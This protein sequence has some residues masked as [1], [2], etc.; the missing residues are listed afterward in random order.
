MNLFFLIIGIAITLW[1]IIE[2]LWTTLWIDGDAGPLTSR[3]TSIIWKGFRLFFAPGS[4]RM[5]SLAG[6]VI[7]FTTVFYWIILLLLGWVL[8][9]YSDPNSIQP[10]PEKTLPGLVDYIWY[11][12]YTTFTV[13]NGDFKPNGSTW[14]ILSSLVAFSGMGMVT[15]TITYLMQVITAVNN[16]RS[17]AS[18]VT[19]VG[20]TAE[21]FVKKQ[22]TGDGFG[23]IELQLNSLN[24]Q[25]ARLSEQ[26]LAFPILH[27]YH[28]ERADKSL[29]LAIGI[30]DDA[31]TI[32]Q[33]GVEEKY[34]PA[35]TILASLRFSIDSFLTTLKM[36]FI[37]PADN[38]PENPNISGLKKNGIPIIPESDFNN[39]I[40]N[41]ED[42]RK[43]ILGLINQGGWKFPS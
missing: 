24:E 23:A 9:F 17:F 25:L 37:H 32:I 12:A 2:A 6:P 43:L 31:L 16:K 14:Q 8:I 33:L 19:S 26:H 38:T 4:H 3:F 1:I 35:E 13:G 21:E 40:K 28:A 7:L 39:K 30:L 36:A 10:N 20:S 15:L 22:W 27:Y 41:E 18:Q 11:I 29:N 5:L 42:R 34:K